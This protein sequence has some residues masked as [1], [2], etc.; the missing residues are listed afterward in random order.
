MLFL[1]RGAYLLN[2]CVLSTDFLQLTCKGSKLQ[3]TIVVAVDS[4]VQLTLTKYMV[5]TQLHSY[6]KLLKSNLLNLGVKSSVSA[7]HV[8]DR[9]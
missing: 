7:Q 1:T 5:S 6:R 4:N 3:M 2:K 9:T 8:L